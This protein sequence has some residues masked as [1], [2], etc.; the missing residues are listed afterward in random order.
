MHSTRHAPPGS[1]IEIP[2]LVTRSLESSSLMA[3]GDY[4][5]WERNSP[6]RRFHHSWEIIHQLDGDLFLIVSRK[7]GDG[8]DDTWTV[9]AHPAHPDAQATA[10]HYE[11]VVS[12]F[13]HSTTHYG[14]FEIQVTLP[15][16]GS[17]LSRLERYSEHLY[18]N[19]PYRRVNR[20][21]IPLQHQGTDPHH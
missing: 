11:S 10:C 12:Q 2:K 5:G 16:G 21:P 18:R 17:L 4:D 13:D 14:P 8:S 1:E 20:E 6:G 19:L 9:L 15:D 3:K 7:Y